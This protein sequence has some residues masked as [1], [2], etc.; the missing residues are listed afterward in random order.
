M[1]LAPYKLYIGDLLIRREEDR[2]KGYGRMLVDHF[3]RSARSKGFTRVHLFM[4]ASESLPF[5]RRLG[6]VGRYSKPGEEG[7]GFYKDLG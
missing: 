5:W 7:G 2:L 4:V 3:E 1:Y 6:Y